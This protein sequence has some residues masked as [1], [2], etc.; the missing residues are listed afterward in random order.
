MGVA[1]G[2]LNHAAILFERMAPI[3]KLIPADY[4][5][6]YRKKLDNAK[7][8]SA[9]STDKAKNVF[10]DKIPEHKDVP[11]PDSKN[12]VKFDD[13]CKED[14]MNI[15]IMNETLRHVIPP[16]VRQMQRDFV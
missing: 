2:T 1:A 15:P 13:S 8:M 4:S 11:I 12:F 14:L 16:E 3:T 7:Q 5:E 10:F 6:N 9:T